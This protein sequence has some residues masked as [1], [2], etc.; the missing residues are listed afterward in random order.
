MIAEPQHP[1]QSTVGPTAGG[2]ATGTP[3][4]ISK[5]KLKRKQHLVEKKS[6][7]RKK[8]RERQACFHLLLLSALQGFD[9]KQHHAASPHII[10]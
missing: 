1:G 6:D 9:P 7:K 8:F 4:K 10:C 3:A 5:T 2:G